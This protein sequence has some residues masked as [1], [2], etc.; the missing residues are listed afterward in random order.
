MQTFFGLLLMTMLIL[1]L[2][3]VAFW[4]GAIVRGWF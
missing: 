4:F 2:V 1:A 3:V